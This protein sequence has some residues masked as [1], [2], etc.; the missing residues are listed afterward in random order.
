MKKTLVT[1]LMLAA[2]TAALTV[3]AQ[4]DPVK[5]QFM[6]QQIEQDRQEIVQGII[7][8]F[9]EE[10]PDIEVEQMPVNEDDYDSKIATLGGSGVLP[11]VVEYSQDQ[12]KTSV[13]NMFTSLDA[14]Q[15][16][17]DTVGEDAFYEGALKVTTT[18]DGSGYVGVPVCSWVQGIWVNTGM[19]AEKEME[20]PADWEGV[21][22]VAEAFYTAIRDAFEATAFGKKL[23]T[24][25]VGGSN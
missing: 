24:V 11:A 20:V 6:H 23:V 1:S 8:A 22:A 3:S 25:T 7:D 19:L 2:L 12:A 10:Y 5:I 4:A 18:E 13:A 16:V 21:L 9:Q 15:A 17:I 14:V